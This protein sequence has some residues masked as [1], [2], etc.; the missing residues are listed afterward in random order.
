M[1]FLNTTHNIGSLITYLVQV[2]QIHFVSNHGI[3]DIWKL[4]SV[5]ELRHSLHSLN[6]I[7]NCMTNPK[8]NF[9]KQRTKRKTYPCDDGLA[10]SWGHFFYGFSSHQKLQEDHPK[11]IDITF[12]SQLAWNPIVTL[13]YLNS[14]STNRDIRIANGNMFSKDSYFDSNFG[15]S[16]KRGQKKN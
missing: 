5:S 13:C 11:S 4:W 2:F 14:L 12:L 9:K 10:L 1:T 16:E 7:R 6:G 8:K 3:D 15:Q